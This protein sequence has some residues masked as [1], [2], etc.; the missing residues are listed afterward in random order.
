MSDKKEDGSLKQLFVTRTMGYL[1]VFPKRELWKKVCNEFNGTFKIS[2]NSGNEVEILRINIP[3][4]NYKIKLSESDTRPLKFEIDFQSEM[5]YELIIGV[6]DSFDKL[7]K[8]LGKKEVEIACDTFDNR[9]LIKSKDPV[10]TKKLF[11]QEIIDGL[12][13]YNVYS[14]AYSSNF[15]KRTSNLITVIS[16]TIDDISSIED[17]I[18]LHMRLIDK[19]EELMLIK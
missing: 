4:K 3:Y 15:K 17:L 18:K 16:R 9:Y 7:L 5:N 8:R 14:L 12:L 19:L 11:T 1:D 13:K 10:L 6:E 2:H